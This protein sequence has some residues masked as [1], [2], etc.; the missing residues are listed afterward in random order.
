MKFK[1]EWE[2]ESSRDS[3]YRLFLK[4]CANAGNRE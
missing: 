2:K 3:V 4:I 1:K